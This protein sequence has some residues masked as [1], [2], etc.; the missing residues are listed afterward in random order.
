[1]DLDWAQPVELSVEKLLE[2]GNPFD[3]NIWVESD[4][5]HQMVEEAIL[6]HSLNPN[7][8]LSFGLERG[9]DWSAQ[10]H[11]DRIAYLV[12]NGWTEPIIIDVGVPSLG[13]Y[14]A[15]PILDGN[16]RFAAAIFRGDETILVEASG[17]VSVLETLLP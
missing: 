14:V 4:I 8:Y 13:V 6:T 9:P 10:E 3:V 12:V 11:A 7:P 2:F 5:T 15:N 16:H 17:S 1:M